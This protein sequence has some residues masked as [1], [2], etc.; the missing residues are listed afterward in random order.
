M[1]E[2]SLRQSRLDGDLSD[3]DVPDVSDVVQAYVVE[4]NKKGCF[5]RCSR[6][7]EG[8]AILKEVCDGFLPNPDVSFPPG[9]L[10]IGKIKQIK[11]SE[12]SSHNPVAQ[13][14]D[15]DMRE[16]VLEKKDA[17]ITL[18][19]VQ[20]GV[21]YKG[22]VERIQA[23]GV[24]VRI[25]NSNVS[26]LVHISEC[27]DSYIKNLSEL[28]QA[29][30]LVKVLVLKADKDSKRISLSM[31]ASHFEEDSDS[32][33]DDDA[34][35]SES[36]KGES[37]KL[38]A[39]STDSDN[40]SAIENAVNNESDEN[41]NDDEDSDDGNEDDSSEGS[42]ESSETESIVVASEDVAVSPPI[43]EQHGLDTDVGFEWEGDIKTNKA[44]DIVTDFSN[45]SDSDSDDD[46]NDDDKNDT[47]KN[48]SRKKQ[49]LRRREQ[50]EISKREKSLADGT[51]DENPETAADFERLLAGAPNSSEIW[52]RYMAFH[53]SL[54]DVQAARDVAN[55][56]IGR[57]E[58]RQEK[59]KMNIWS[60]LLTLELKYGTE[61]SVQETVDRAS[62]H[63]NPKHVYLRTC[64]IC[65]REALAG[66]PDHMRRADE[67]FAKMCK[68]FKD[69]KK[70]W[71]SHFEYLLQTNRH[72]EAHALSKRALLSLP[73]YKQVE[74]MAKFAQ[75]VFE[76]GKAER[77]RTLFD[78]LLQLHPKRLD[79]F[80]V[81]VDKEVKFGDTEIARS[82]FQ[83][84]AN[85]N[86]AR[87]N[88]KLTDKQMKSFFKKWFSFE[89]EHGTD[90]SQDN[91][92]NAAR[93]YVE[94]ITE[95]K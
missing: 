22:L 8:R 68:K 34:S 78:G 3:D 60:A 77:A 40:D 48:K 87:I 81:Y 94:R 47:K 13:F 73:K 89:Q 36:S 17:Q 66:S 41:S 10:V 86:D 29:G 83:R 11:P 51:A 67:M 32:E 82:L 21:K 31:K 69:K 37:S 52:I 4:T 44:S 80:F 56:A 88:L 28:F 63:S 70:V 14:I 84:V 74:T 49:A 61:S 79:L 50:E 91:V 53:L 46:N 24:F 75:L 95:S 26:G 71:V 12:P 57:I 5:V 20:V 2:V 33:D 1:V 62:Q 72:E 15:I 90:E 16:S 23:F 85:P 54:A 6:Q 65:S 27:S 59:E 42:S 45:K 76:F 43:S 9:R 25:Q 92:K 19:N 58:F 55:R 38:H 93:E 18:E 35:D 39:N 64:E 7:I 30:D